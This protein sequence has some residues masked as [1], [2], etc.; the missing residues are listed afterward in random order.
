MPIASRT[1]KPGGYVGDKRPASD[2][3]GF[4]VH[5][6]EGNNVAA[7]LSRDPARG[8]SVQYTVEQDAEIIAMVPE[9]RSAGSVNPSTIRTDD[10]PY[11]GASHAKYVLGDLWRNP[12]R[13]V[14]AV[15]VAG[16]ARV[17]PNDRQVLALVRLF[18]DC[19]TR[20]PKLLKPLGH[21]DLQN[22]KPCPGNTPA[23]KRMF[24]LMGGHGKD[25]RKERPVMSTVGFVPDQ[26]ATLK[27]N[28]ALFEVI[29]DEAFAHAGDPLVRPTFG[30]SKD[31][32]WRLV[33]ADSPGDPDQTLDRT[34][35][36]KASDVTSVKVVPPAPPDIDLVVKQAR[37]G[38][39]DQV[40]LAVQGIVA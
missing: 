17:G 38:M 22:V 1:V 4:L 18:N 23:I 13:G 19:L 5:M 6:A 26:Y 16:T 10:D 14:I 31:R 3:R 25:Y 30:T 21:R 28:A 34:A 7:Y 2:I 35:W 29:G 15:E 24:A 27:D 20:Y 9:D 37:K 32:K 33:A 11:Y 39:Q 36:V 12:N 8:V 40:L